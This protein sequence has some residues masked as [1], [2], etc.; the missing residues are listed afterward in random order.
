MLRLLAALATVL[1]L[2]VPSQ[3]RTADT[4]IFDRHAVSGSYNYGPVLASPRSNRIKAKRKK[5]KIV[6]Q[7]NN[8]VKIKYIATEAPQN[9]AAVPLVLAARAYIG[10]NPTGWRRLWC[11]RFMAM[12]VPIAA[13]KVRNPNLARD[14]AALE[15]TEPKVGAIVVLSRG[16]GGHIGVVSGFDK[17][18][19]PIVI[20]GN[21]G[22]KVGEGTYPRHRVIAWV[23]Q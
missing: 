11:A 1:V 22:G 10:S 18:G 3:A 5:F 20:S 19:N 16:R 7:H 21:H 15:K 23:A 14:W 9:T 13:A 6:R 12:L 4:S 8:T 17:R 2:T